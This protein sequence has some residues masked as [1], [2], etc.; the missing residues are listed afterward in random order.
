MSREEV[1]GNGSRMD[2]RKE[3]LEAVEADNHPYKIY[4]I[5]TRQAAIIACLFILFLPFKEVSD[6]SKNF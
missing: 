6:S 4:N 5:I 3:R 2:K 1:A